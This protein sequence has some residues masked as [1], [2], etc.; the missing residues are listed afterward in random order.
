MVGVVGAEGQQES[1][2]TQDPAA[3][4]LGAAVEAAVEAEVALAPSQ[5][6]FALWKGED[7]LKCTGT[8]VAQADAEQLP[9]GPT[10]FPVLTASLYQPKYLLDP[11][12]NYLSV[13]T[14]EETTLT[15]GVSIFQCLIKSSEMDQTNMVCN[16]VTT[17]DGVFSAQGYCD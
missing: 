6:H 7:K 16:L 3:A 9:A 8:N 11:S 15:R 13:Q 4:V 1:C 14:W 5:G 2:P 12:P 10:T 17:T